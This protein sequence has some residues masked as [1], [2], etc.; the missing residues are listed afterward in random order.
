VGDASPAGP[1]DEVKLRLAELAAS[2]GERG[3]LM[4]FS[5]YGLPIELVLRAEVYDWL[6]PAPYARAVATV[7]IA[8][9]ALEIVFLADHNAVADDE[10]EGH[11][12]Q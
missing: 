10:R 8:E 1:G 2:L 11:Q 7:G 9:L 6:Q 4:A 12:H 5:V 3:F